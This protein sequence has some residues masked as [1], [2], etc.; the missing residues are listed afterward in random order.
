MN[1]INPRTPTPM[2]TFTGV[3]SERRK[4][5]ARTRANG[6]VTTANAPEKNVI[7]GTADNAGEVA[8]KPNK[9][10]SLSTK[11]S[12]NTHPGVISAAATDTVIL[13]GLS[14][15]GV[16]SGLNGIRVLTAGTVL[17]ED[18]TISAFTQ[19]GVDISAN[20]SVKVVVRREPAPVMK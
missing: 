6:V 2:M 11:A 12:P 16:S 14:I 10:N 19:Y 9:P 1:A 13:R 5:T 15:G 18:C 17:I 20:V 7:A 4:T 8:A 3:L